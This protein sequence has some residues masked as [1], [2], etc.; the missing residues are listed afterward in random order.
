MII[1][2][3]LVILAIFLV[4]GW[5]ITTE[6]FQQRYWRKRV[7]AGD[8]QIVEALLN[9]AFATWKRARPPRGLPTNLW[10][11]VQAA[12]LIAVTGDT[13][14]VS[15]SA[16]GEFRT[17]HGKRVQVSTALDEAIALAAK[18]AD[19]LLYDVP[20]LRL[21]SVRVDIYSTFTGSDGTPVQRPILTTTA[22]RSAADAIAWESMDPSEIL[23]RFATHYRRSPAGQG[24]PIELDAAVEAG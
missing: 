17:E 12:Q 15:S 6:M 18:L 24:L 19:M 22:S 9:E 10:A 7:E 21:A 2:G 14:I 11:G 20:N 5:A 23:G 13:A 4:T 8:E 3:S 1:I 16:E